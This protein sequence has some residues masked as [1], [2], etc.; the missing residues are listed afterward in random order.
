MPASQTVTERSDVTIR[1]LRI[2]NLCKTYPGD[3]RALQ[4]VSIPINEG[5]FVSLLGPS[6]CGKTTIL[7]SIAGLEH[8]DSGRISVGNDVLTDVAAGILLPPEQ[9]HLGLVFQSYALWPHM[10]V[11]K[12]LAFALK[13]RKVSK[14]DI[15]RR[16]GEALEL[17]GLA[18]MADRY[19]YQMSG[20]QQQRV[21]L[22]RAVVA[23]PRVLLLDEPLSNL[24]AKVRD[25]ARSWLREFQQRLGITAVYVTHDQS[26]ALAIS[27]RIAVMSSGKLLQYGT[28]HQIYE[29]PKTRFVA[30]FIGR[31]S[32]LEGVV[33]SNR[34]GL[35]ELR[36][37]TGETL[38][39]HSDESNQP[40]AEVTLA[41][42]SE[43]IRAAAADEQANVVAGT[44]RSSVYVGSVYEYEV[45][46]D[47][48]TLKFESPEFLANG[49]TRLVLP[50]ESIVVL[51]SDD[52][53][54]VDR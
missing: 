39:A 47:G 7:N 41:V 15:E 45:H 11:F 10:T 14:A 20:G 29:R 34:E 36:T 32:F 30:D 44:L 43:R 25:S 18:G 5:E 17:V 27:D 46:T 42:R 51:A 9:R 54:S 16:I 6:G 19:P 4:D 35:V 49:P 13:L 50:P 8:P 53:K 21:A 2:E 37:E 1:D 26:E 24:D 33:V 28:P 48:G 52:A 38:F 31:S 22:A 12:N 23:Q 3:V 40:G